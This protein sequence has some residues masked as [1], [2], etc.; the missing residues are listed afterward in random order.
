MIKDG[1]CIPL[2]SVR[3]LRDLYLFTAV[4][5]YLNQTLITFFLCAFP[6]LRL[7]FGIS[8]RDCAKQ[9]PWFI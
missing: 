3:D 8:K 6:T 4:F 9:K 1:V 7:P 5:I 2:F